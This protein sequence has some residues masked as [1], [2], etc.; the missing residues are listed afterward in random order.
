MKGQKPALQLA[1]SPRTR[2][3]YPPRDNEYSPF[4]DSSEAN[5]PPDKT[6]AAGNLA[7]L[8]ETL[9]YDSQKLHQVVP[10]RD[11]CPGF[12]QAYGSFLKTYP[13]Y[14]L[15]WILDTL[16]R[17]DFSRLALSGETYVDYMG[18]SLHP[19]SL[20]QCHAAFLSKTVMG[21]THSVSNRY[22]ATRCLSFM[23]CAN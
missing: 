20:V 17:S 18:G 10:A 8:P 19:E 12:V 15:T 4:Q 2:L 22:A 1:T 7:Y 5:F 11:S 6:L 23:Q 13:E 16:R 21:N 14:Q 3:S 9:L